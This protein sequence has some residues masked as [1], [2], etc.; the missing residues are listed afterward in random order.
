MLYSIS[1]LSSKMFIILNII[2]IL[3]L[4]FKLSV[5]IKNIIYLHKKTNGTKK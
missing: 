5:H 3:I 4:I 1:I 2:F